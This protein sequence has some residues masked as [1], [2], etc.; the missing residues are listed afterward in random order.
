M[1]GKFADNLPLGVQGQARR[2]TSTLI[3]CR[4]IISVA[5]GPQAAFALS[6]GFL[7]STVFHRQP[8]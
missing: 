8:M 4:K 2:G 5:G 3:G 6:G 1:L 7:I